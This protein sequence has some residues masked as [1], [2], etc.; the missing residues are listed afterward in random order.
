MNNVYQSGP[1]LLQYCAL[2]PWHAMQEPQSFVFSPHCEICFK[3]KTPWLEFIL[4]QTWQFHMVGYMKLWK[5]HSLV[6]KTILIFRCLW[7]H[8]YADYIKF[9]PYSVNRAPLSDILDL[10]NVNKIQLSFLIFPCMSDMLKKTLTL[11]GQNF[12]LTRLV[13]WAVT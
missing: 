9:L 5:T 12:P 4:I 13:W 6:T 2:Q 3:H 11:E 7:K 1:S 8:R 10:Y